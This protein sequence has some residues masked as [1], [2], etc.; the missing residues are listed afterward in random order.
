MPPATRSKSAATPAKQGGKGPKTKEVQKNRP[1]PLKSALRSTLQGPVRARQVAFSTEDDPNM[2]H[3]HLRTT[4]YPSP[5]QMQSEKFSPKVPIDHSKRKEREE[6]LK[7]VEILIGAKDKRAWGLPTPPQSPRGG[8]IS[9]FIG[10]KKGPVEESAKKPADT[11]MPEKTGKAEPPKEEE[12]V[13]LTSMHIDWVRDTIPEGLVLPASIEN[14]LIKPDA[15]IHMEEICTAFDF[16][17]TQIQ[18]HC[19]AFYCP[20][21]PARKE[22]IPSFTYLK[23]KHPEL[24]RYIQYVADGSQYGWDNL[25]KIGPQRENLVY[26]IISRAIIAHVFDAELF[27]ASIEHKEALLEMCRE[28]L[29][30]DAFVRNT[31]R[32]EIIRSILLNEATRHSEAPYTYFTPAINSLSTRIHHMLTP[33]H[34]PEYASHIPPAKPL[35]TIIQTALKIHLAIRL[36]GANGTVYRFELPHK[37]SPWDRQTM[38]CINQIKMDLTVHHGEEP[39]VKIAC[40]PAVYATVPGGPTLERFED[41]AFVEEWKNTADPDV[42]VDSDADSDADS[43][44]EGK[45]NE[46]EYENGNGNER[47]K[48]GSKPIITT[49][50]ITLADVVLEN[51]PSS[52]ATF[53]TLSQTMAAEQATMSDKRFHNLTGINRA[54]NNRINK[55]VRRAP[56]VLSRAV[57][58]GLAAA[59]SFYL[60]RNRNKMAVLHVVPAMNKWWKQMKTPEQVVKAITATAVKTAAAT[61]TTTTMMTLT[62]ETV[63]SKA[64]AGF[65]TPP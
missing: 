65:T 36:A 2:V 38:N 9:P 18:S 59:A 53:L 7:R 21:K 45:E 62:P 49:Y 61:T 52:R 25:I 50:P 35:R 3:V 17:K 64:A 22:A 46:Y 44:E 60:Y 28:Y 24:F 34:D 8:R 51:T 10:P 29:Y 56:G 15:D 20:E 1:P 11:V 48:T 47:K 32:A 23:V 40:F 5:A 27:G 16:L 58:L 39:L 12:L 55:I 37:L 54:R 4:P 41:P 57:K 6:L 30:F 26:G 14:I 42:N 19:R 13:P 33:L 43:D 63:L 31:H